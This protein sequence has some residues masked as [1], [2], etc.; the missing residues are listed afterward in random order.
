MKQLSVLNKLHELSNRQELD[1]DYRPA[2][3]EA[4]SIIRQ[5]NLDK[6]YIEK[7][8]HEI[9]THKSK[10]AILTD[11]IRLVREDNRILR[12]NLELGGKIL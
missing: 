1:H 11:D 4:M 6:T 10:I 2:L 7:L 8:K 12:E 9:L 3:K 5:N